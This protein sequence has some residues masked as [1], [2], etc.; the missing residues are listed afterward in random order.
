MPMMSTFA[1]ASRRGFAPPMLAANSYHV[2]R[3]LRFRAGASAHL[4][5]TFGTPTNNTTWSLS[6]WLKGVIP[7]GAG[8]YTIIGTTA[9]GNDIQFGGTGSGAAN[10]L[11]FDTSGSPVASS[12][13]LFRDPTAWGHLFVVS[14]GT[15]VVGYWNGVQVLSYTG[16]LAAFNTANGHTI[17]KWFTTDYAD[18]YMADFIF[19]DGQ[20][21]TAASFGETDA[22]TGAWNPKAYAGTFGNN[23]FWL[24]FA[25]NSSTTNVARDDAGGAAGAGAGS[26]DWTTN[27]ISVTA[28]TGNDSLTDTPTN[29]GTDTGAGGEVRGNYPTLDPLTASTNLTLSE[30]NLKATCNTNASFNWATGTLRIRQGDGKPFWEENVTAVGADHAFGMSPYVGIAPSVA[31]ASSTLMNG[32]GCVVY[33]NTGVIKVAGSNV[34][35]GLATFTTGDTI[36]ALVDYSGSTPTIQFYKLVTGAWVAVGTAVS[37]TAGADYCPLFGTDISGVIGPV[38]FGQRAYAAT[39]PGSGKAFCT[40]NMSTNTVALPSTFAGNGNA[41][42][43]SVYAGGI[44][45]TVTINGNVA[46]AGTHFDKL[47]TGMKLRTSSSS[48]NTSGSNTVSAAT[49]G[50]HIKYARAQAN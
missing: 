19:V 38:N 43:P 39:A 46:T 41:D 4:S 2:Q 27:N 14:N 29:Y 33:Q 12:S 6:V 28:G 10:K 23:G 21:L 44:V 17:G 16:T 9:L 47:A 18:G 25:D 35:T 40:Q 36:G 49:Y 24:S 13:A 5:R 1:S 15:T 42:G 32:A 11:K 50:I 22:I 20:A 45:A 8:N 31:T 37:G 34:Q 48:Y 26:N 7:P 30:G 3:S